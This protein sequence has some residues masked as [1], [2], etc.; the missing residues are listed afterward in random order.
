MPEIIEVDLRGV[1]MPQHLQRA[2]EAVAKA[3]EGNE[4][5][6]TT[7]QEVVIKYVPSAAAKDGLKMR[8]SMPDEDVWRIKLTLKT[9]E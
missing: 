2:T 5:V 3:N 8:M 7:D 4:V 1:P 6:L 9:D